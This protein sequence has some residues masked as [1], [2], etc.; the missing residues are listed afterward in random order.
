MTASKVNDVDVVAYAR[1]V[2]GVVVV[3]EY[4][5]TSELADGNLRNI[6]H[7]V[8]R[9]ALGVFTDQSGFMRTDGV[10][11]TEK[12]DGKIRIRESSIL[13]DHFDHILGP[14]VGVGASADNSGFLDRH[15]VGSA[16]YG[17]GGAEDQI[18]AIVFLHDLEKRESRVK[19]VSVVGDR[20]SDGFTDCLV[21]CEMDNSVG[22]FCREK[23]AE[24][25]FVSNIEFIEREIRADDGLDSV[26]CFGLAVGKVVRNN[27]LVSELCNFNRGVRADVARAA[28]K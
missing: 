13:Q 24:L 15:F 14:A 17:S 6:G 11:V 2:L 18:V 12:N 16:V 4:G 7:E 20:L 25:F 9:N 10:E 5:E 26:E 23:R 22:L 3:T 28:C 19:V 8:V 27:D 21:A 1:T